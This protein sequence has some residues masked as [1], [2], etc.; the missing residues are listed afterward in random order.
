[1]FL[2]P[3]P[4]TPGY[5]WECYTSCF[6]LCTQIRNP[7]VKTGRGKEEELRPNYKRALIYY[8]KPNRCF[9]KLQISDEQRRLS[10]L[11]C[12]PASALSHRPLPNCFTS[13]V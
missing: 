3:P 1:M 8:C 4:S 6:E 13:L 2:Q 12:A 5:C 7:E 11:R 10:K 9:L